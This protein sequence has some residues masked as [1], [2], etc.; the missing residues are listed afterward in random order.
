MDKSRTKSVESLESPTT[1]HSV[2]TSTANSLLQATTTAAT[3]PQQQQQQLHHPQQPSPFSDRIIL[4]LNITPREE[5]LT[6][7]VSLPA[8]PVL[9]TNSSTV[10]SADSTDGTALPEPKPISLAA[11]NHHQMSLQSIPLSVQSMKRVPSPIRAQISAPCQAPKYT[12]KAASTPF[13]PSIKVVSTS[14]ARNES[15]PAATP[16]K[17]L[18]YIIKPLTGGVTATPAT[19]E[20]SKDIDNVLAGMMSGLQSM[21]MEHSVE[22]SPLSDERGL[23]SDDV[24]SASIVESA[25]NKN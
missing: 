7:S 1:G 9:C 14:T 4:P 23:V 5:R 18:S 8:T 2:F 6:Q 15:L 12:S 21:Q 22:L 24:V 19:A 16:L 17:P 20:I 25:A 13:A 3:L 11:S 10:A